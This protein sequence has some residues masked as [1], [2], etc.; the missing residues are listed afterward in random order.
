MSTT[1]YKILSVIPMKVFS[2]HSMG[3]WWN[4]STLVTTYRLLDTWAPSYNSFKHYT[5]MEI[6][7]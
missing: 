1:A 6:T 2:L 7:V 5:T 4:L 3:S